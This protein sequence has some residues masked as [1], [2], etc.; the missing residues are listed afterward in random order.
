MA[1]KKLNKKMAIIG[2][3]VLMLVGMALIVAFLKL[4]KDPEK[5][6]EDAQVALEQN[7]YEKAVENYGKA[8]GATKAPEGKIDIYFTLS[9]LFLTDNEYH[10]PDWKKALACWGN[11]INLDPKNIEAKQH[12]LDFY[13]EIGKN[14]QDTAWR[15][16]ETNAKDIIDITKEKGR[17]VDLK[18]EKAL[19][20]ARYM[21][22]KTG[23][24]TDRLALI[25]QAIAD[26]ESILERDPEDV[27][28]VVMLSDAWV[29]KGGLGL[30]QGLTDAM[31]QAVAEAYKVLDNA[32][33]RMPEAPEPAVARF[34]T[35][36]T[37]WRNYRYGDP[38]AKEN[39]IAGAKQLVTQYPQK[40]EAYTAAA[41]I[42]RNYYSSFSKA[43]DYAARAAELEPQ[44]VEC[45]LLQGQLFFQ[46][47][48]VENEPKFLNDA[49]AVVKASL[50]YPD[51]QDITGPREIVN[52][53]FR[54]NIFSLL[55]AYEL[56][57]A[58]ELPESDEAGRQARIQNAEKH[59]HEIEQIYGT[60]D[61]MF[62]VKWRGML[63]YAHG[64]R[65]EAVRKLHNAYEQMAAIQHYDIQL[66]STL[67]DLLKDQQAVGYRRRLLASILTPDRLPSL[68][69]DLILD[70]V[71]LDLEL[72][73]NDDAISVCQFYQEYLREDEVS[74]RLLAQAYTASGRFDEAQ[75]VLD[76][77]D[78]ASPAAIQTRID[79]LTARLRR[80]INSRIAEQQQ[81]GVTQIDLSAMGDD[82]TRFRDERHSLIM[83]LLRT[84]PDQVS[85]A[86]ALELCNSY[87]LAGQTDMALELSGEFLKHYSENVSIKVIDR[88]ARE[89]E[90]AK[91][92]VE[93]RKELMLE[94][95][96]QVSDPKERALTLAQYYEQN[97]ETE[98]AV[99]H[100]QNAYDIDKDYRALAKLFDQ[101]LGADNITRAKEIAEIVRKGNLDG[102]E[103]DIFLSQ[104]DIRNKDFDSALRRLNNCIKFRPLNPNIYFIRSEVYEAKGDTGLAIKDM[105]EAV[106]IHPLN[107][108]HARRLAVL[109]Y[110]RNRELGS[111]ATVDQIAEADS[112]IKNA[113]RLNPQESQLQTLYAS[114]ISDREPEQALA[115]VQRLQKASPTLYN[116]MMLGR[117]A[118]NMAVREVSPER[119][120]HLFDIAGEAFANAYQLDPENQETLETYT[121]Y[122]RLT[123]QNEKAERLLGEDRNMLW[124]LYVRG[125]RYEKAKEILDELFAADPKNPELIQGL[126]NVAQQMRDTEAVKTYGPLLVE[127]SP[128][129]ES[130]LLMIQTML[131][132][133]LTDEADE[134]LTDYIA[135]NPDDDRARLLR[136]WATVRKGELEQGMAQLD[137][138]LQDNAENSQAWGLKGQV[139]SFLNQYNKAVESFQKS[140]MLND[141]PATQLELA[142]AYIRAGRVTEAIGELN[143]A[144]Q[145]DQAPPAARA[146]LEQLYL[147][148][149]R[150]RELQDFYAKSTEKYP[151][152]YYW[153]FKAANFYLNQKDF[154]KAN[155]MISRAWDVVRKGDR[156]NLEVADLMMEILRKSGRKEPFY[157]FASA[158]TDDDYAVVAYSH[159]AQDKAETGGRTAALDYFYKALDKAGVNQMFIYNILDSMNTSLG[160]REVAT[161]CQTQLAKN[162]D[163]LAAN[164][165]M[166]DLLAKR[167]DYHEAN[168]YIDKCLAVVGTESPLW[169]NYMTQKANT[170][171]AAYMKTSD[172]EYFRQAID[173]F[174]G[175]LERNPNNHSVL[176]NVAYLLTDNNEQLEK[177]AEYAQRA[178]ELSPNN[179]NYM[180][181]LA[182]TMLKNKKFSEAEQV[183]QRAIQVF[184]RDEKQ[185]TPWDVYYHLGMA[186]EG[187]TQNLPAE[188]SYRKA[189]EM[190]G[191]N[192][193]ESNR[194]KLQDAIKRVAGVSGF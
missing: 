29:V 74:N 137:A 4:S 51:A 8:L 11:I 108:L 60:G 31:D 163:S 32:I 58:H 71:R 65:D 105:Q 17:P 55:T 34:Q 171:I 104:I 173:I 77:M 120:Q 50:D 73:A 158:H 127:V 7:D 169:A 18:N 190:G 40:Y 186:Q 63:D 48:Q 113:I 159:L 45:A 117:V 41:V 100:Y 59:I 75:Q 103:G 98:M 2:T 124:K 39:V 81:Q 143:S 46:K 25:E 133:G 172:Q 174:D 176:N 1:K 66:V 111:K 54:L 116:N 115:I 187:L 16:V 94:V 37:L 6:L 109:L 139:H 83:K 70:Y 114:F 119:K 20:H 9:K 80:E 170:V 76:K 148:N 188:Q 106:N 134:K 69:P 5:F 138:Y 78:K 177:A 30:Q 149:N 126:L 156:T 182:Y 123:G 3:V 183:L 33:A 131:E 193:S 165:V 35:P 180:D 185:P 21:I 179:A 91:V 150:V 178:V 129:Q 43:M 93:R 146:L 89:P 42:C 90:P 160:P 121:E 64:K 56:A 95:A 142:R 67:N 44:K 13:Y 144:L 28:V 189:L 38:P 49:I 110:N 145:N 14:G 22:A 162:P 72:F 152:S 102:C 168:T 24:T 184:D 157:K 153:Y 181:T 101:A 84:A 154:T 12:I 147:E 10:D 52:K 175:I 140:K 192:L 118:L 23:Q 26:L 15:S 87:V 97:G 27:D 92:T 107:P 128:S 99:E 96:Q 166:Y 125:G 167:G 194:T 79:L 191:N 86:T 53:Q 85:E 88:I 112:A 155:D 47:Y 122:L 19:A 135:R 68:D 61:N 151:D 36:I 62:V 130:E 161:W 141:N 164:Y 82:I 136:A 57:A 132:V